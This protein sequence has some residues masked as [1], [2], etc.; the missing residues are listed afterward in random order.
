MRLVAIGSA[1][2]LRGCRSSKSL[3]STSVL[4]VG[5][6]AV[7]TCKDPRA[8]D[9]GPTGFHELTRKPTDREEPTCSVFETAK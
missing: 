2:P 9:A 4:A 8:R 6:R 7:A 1:V 5:Q 3:A